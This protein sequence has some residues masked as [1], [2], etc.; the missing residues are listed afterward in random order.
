MWKLLTTGES[1]SVGDQI[2]FLGTYAGKKQDPYTVV[3]TEQHYFQ[4]LQATDRTPVAETK[5]FT[6][7]I[8]YFEIGYYHKLEIWID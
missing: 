3:K 8:K 5:L 7:V 4:V 2:R 1:V 6:K